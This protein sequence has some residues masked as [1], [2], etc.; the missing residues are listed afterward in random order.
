MEESE[1]DKRMRGEELQALRR[2]P[3]K[4]GAHSHIEEDSKH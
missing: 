4:E 3:G 2:E 1:R